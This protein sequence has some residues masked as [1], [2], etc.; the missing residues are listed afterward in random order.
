MSK[1]CPRKAGEPMKK[2]LSLFVIA[3]CLVLIPAYYINKSGAEVSAYQAPPR[4]IYIAD[5][6]V[7][8]PAYTA[9]FVVSYHPFPGT[10]KRFEDRTGIPAEVFDQMAEDAGI[11]SAYAAARFVLE[12]GWGK[13]DLWINYNNPAGIKCGQRYCRYAT[14]RDGLTAMFN[15]MADYYTNGLTNV[16]QQSERWSASDDTET[17]LE[18]MEGFRDE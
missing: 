2:L 14:P 10:G 18:I 8:D 6:P 7:D 3:A 11:S 4:A 17:I 5:L 12:T 15:L 13:S 1:S 9:D 16:V